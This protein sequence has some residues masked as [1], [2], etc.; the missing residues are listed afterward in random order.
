MGW[1]NNIIVDL[2]EKGLR[3]CN[4]FVSFCKESTVSF[5]KVTILVCK[6]VSQKPQFP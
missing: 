6:L 3:V 1:E 2:K 4:G 5:C